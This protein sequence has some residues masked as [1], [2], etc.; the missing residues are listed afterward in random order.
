MKKLCLILAVV[1]LLLSCTACVERR[2]KANAY[3]LYT[4][5]KYLY[6]DGYD[7]TVTIRMQE[8]AGDVVSGTLRVKVQG[9]NAEIT[10][11][12]SDAARYL[13]GEIAYQSGY[14]YVDDYDETQYSEDKLKVSMTKEEFKKDVMGFFGIAVFATEFP[15]FSAES[16]ESI[17]FSE[18]GDYRSFSTDLSVE[19]ICA[20]LGEE[21]LQEAHGSMA[22]S[23]DGNGDMRRMVLIM[24]V[25][26]ADGVHRSFEI[27]YD[28]K[29]PGFMPAILPP[30]DADQYY[31]LT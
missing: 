14:F 2:P 10:R 21:T 26:Y 27:V 3:E 13:I 16:L 4:N 5:A 8:G 15:S 9:N 29:N 7:A 31:D 19:S 20:Y 28:F 6:I 24:H 30:T 1:L 12:N 22:V 17:E 25:T 11:S 23:F 18:K